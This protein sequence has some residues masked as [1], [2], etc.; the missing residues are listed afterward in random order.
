VTDR[1]Q[2]DRD[3][4][5]RPRNARERDQLG[6]PGA[7]H[8]GTVPAGDPTGALDPRAALLR[9]QALLREDRPFAAHEVFEECWKATSGS[10]RGLWRGLAQLAVGVTHARRAN[11]AGA[12]AV[13]TRAMDTLATYEPD[14]PYDVDVAG[15]REW[16]AATLTDLTRCEHPPPLLR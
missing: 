12:V 14:P 11:P 16:I 15:I 4:Q 10:P 5:G 6:R 13:L 9:G 1:P 7:A 8:T 2:R 3:A